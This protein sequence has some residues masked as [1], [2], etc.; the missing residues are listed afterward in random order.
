MNLISSNIFRCS[1][2]ELQPVI[3]ILF[4]GLL[5]M[6]SEE[7]AE[8]VRNAA[9]VTLAIIPAKCPEVFLQRRDLVVVLFDKITQVQNKNVYLFVFIIYYFQ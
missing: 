2:E 3:N 7:Y 8:D 6:T 4:N 1:K 9:Y 5:K